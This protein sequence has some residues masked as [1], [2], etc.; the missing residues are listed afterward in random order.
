MKQQH[1]ACET[2]TFLLIPHTVTDLAQLAARPDEYLV[3][4]DAEPKRAA[5]IWFDRAARNPYGGDGC[6]QIRYFEAQLIPLELWDDTVGIWIALLDAMENFLA[7]GVGR[8]D[9]SPEFSLVG[10]IHGASFSAHGVSHQVD[11]LDVIPAV[12]DGAQR[13]FSWVE[14]MVGSTYPEII[15]RIQAMTV[16][17]NSFSPTRAS[18]KES[19]PRA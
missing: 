5:N 9:Y 4:I 10:S 16:S 2:E 7:T 1:Q 6:V 15:E 11:P 3:S 13:Y 8:S 19:H 14:N 18:A 12:L 17:L